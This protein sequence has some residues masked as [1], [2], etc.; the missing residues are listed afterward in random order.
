MTRRTRHTP[1]RPTYGAALRIARLIFALAQRPGG[2]KMD[3]A[4]ALLG[5]S[6]RTLLRY[7]AACRTGLRT[8]D[9]EPVIQHRA[10]RLIL[11]GDLTLLSALEVD[12]DG[13][14][15]W[16]QRGRRAA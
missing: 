1:R 15:P 16:A 12:A 9:G 4:L 13:E 7:L 10:G 5:I 8:A 11:A 14:N 6:E 2:L 3:A